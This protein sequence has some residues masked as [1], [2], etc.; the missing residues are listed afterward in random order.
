M[1]TLKHIALSLYVLNMIISVY[2]A[3]DTGQAGWI[4]SS[5]GWFVASLNQWGYILTEK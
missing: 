5:M 2:S 3:I 1:K 4:V